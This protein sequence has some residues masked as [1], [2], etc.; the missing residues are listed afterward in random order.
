MGVE[1]WSWVGAI[2]T[3][4]VIG[5]IAAMFTKK[6]PLVDRIGGDM[7]PVDSLSTFRT[8]APGIWSA[9]LIRQSGNLHRDLG[10]FPS[11]K[12]ALSGCRSG[13]QQGLCSR[14]RQ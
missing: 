8:F 13:T 4:F 7:V 5:G 9:A 11:A 10:T 1:F 2:V 14:F 12:A 6:D 3:L